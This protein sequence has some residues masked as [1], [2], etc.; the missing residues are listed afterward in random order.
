M[1]KII[2]LLMTVVGVWIGVE[3]Y[4]NGT[5]NAFGG[6]LAF[7]EESDEGGARDTRTVP[8]RAGDKARRAHQQADDRRNRLLGE[9]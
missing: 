3:V 1:G 9:D 5:Q 6:A 7:L 4:L 8:Q 2:G